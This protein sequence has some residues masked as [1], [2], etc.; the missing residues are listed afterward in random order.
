M[1]DTAH[2]P[3]RLSEIVTDGEQA[4]KLLQSNS[5]SA[6]ASLNPDLACQGCPNTDTRVEV[7]LRMT[8]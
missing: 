6:S 5:S 8:L 2:L 4:R 3:R 1:E 7:S